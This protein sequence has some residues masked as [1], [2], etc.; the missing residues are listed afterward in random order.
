[1]GIPVSQL[2]RALWE[3]EENKSFWERWFFTDPAIKKLKNLFT[4]YKEIPGQEIEKY[5]I[6]ELLEEFKKN[7]LIRPK[8]ESA[9]NSI[10]SLLGIKDDIINCFDLRKRNKIKQ[11]IEIFNAFENPTEILERLNCVINANDHRKKIIFKVINKP[12]KIGQNKIEVYLEKNK[13][14]N[15]YPEKKEIINSENN[16][17]SKHILF[18]KKAKNCSISERS[19]TSEKIEVGK[20]KEVIETYDAEKAWWKKFSL[21]AFDNPAIKILRLILVNYRNSESEE[22]IDK[23]YVLCLISKLIESP[24]INT[25]NP[26]S[27]NALKRLFGVE[28]EDF[29]LTDKKE[30][31]MVNVIFTYSEN[32]IQMIKEIL[33]HRNSGIT[34]ESLCL[35]NILCVNN[36]N[37]N[38]YKNPLYMLYEKTLETLKDE[39]FSRF[40]KI[41]FNTVGKENPQIQNDI[42]ALH[43]LYK[44]NVVD[45]NEFSLPE[46]NN[47]NREEILEK[48]RNLHKINQF[49]YQEEKLREYL[50]NFNNSIEKSILLLKM[51][52]KK[53]EG[54]TEKSIK[55]WISG[56]SEDCC[57]LINRNIDLLIQENIITK[58]LF[59]K[60][61]NMNEITL[62]NLTSLLNEK[63][64]RLKN[65]GTRNYNYKFTKKSPADFQE[66]QINSLFKKGAAYFYK[67]GKNLKIFIRSGTSFLYF[68]IPENLKNDKNVKKF[69]QKLNEKDSTS[70]SLWSRDSV[71]ISDITC[72][73]DEIVEFI[74][75]RTNYK[76]PI[77]KLK[78]EVET[79][80]KMT[81][82]EYSE[83]LKYFLENGRFKFSQTAKPPSLLSQKNLFTNPKKTSEHNLSI[84]ASLTA[85]VSPRLV[86]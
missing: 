43:I 50:K 72:V 5:E 6:T 22:E 60:M 54:I 45:K 47:L 21:G 73:P 16:D 26:T 80:S 23:T 14:C 8:S 11:I 64:T 25:E 31:G 1:M 77:E 56:L 70:S 49:S 84:A 68:D 71:T 28:E 62:K 61:K 20:L 55:G 36:P 4:K 15:L 9:Q 37:I 76:S 85:P 58:D 39:N 74:K 52:S 13:I 24:M 78:E 66:H 57:K 29:D 83:S 27:Y 41:Y 40:L 51:T 81:D 3:Y 44:A 75:S 46:I 19:L 82:E 30:L 38:L 7:R 69:I 17:S 48:M 2:Q 86:C 34:T 18:V 67:E 65:A 59:E 32:P 53:I 35:E 10:K 12:D 42:E 63:I 79:F 33:K